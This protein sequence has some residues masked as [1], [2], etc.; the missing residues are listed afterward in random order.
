M[1][2]L[3]R[4]S[5][6]V[7]GSGTEILSRRCDPIARPAQHPCHSGPLVS[8]CLAKSLFSIRAE[9]L[10]LDAAHLPYAARSGRWQGM[11]RAPLS[12]GSEYRGHTV[13]QRVTVRARSSAFV[14]GVTGRKRKG[15][16]VEGGERVAKPVVGEL[17][18]PLEPTPKWGLVPHVPSYQTICCV[19]PPPLKG[20]IEREDGGPVPKSVCTRNAPHHLSLQ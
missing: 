20:R 13:V 8:T 7:I 1:H 9:G 5:S 17:R 15:E 11:N 10:S 14:R 4:V 6:I 12:G 18:D 2:G 16:G 19:D 3:L